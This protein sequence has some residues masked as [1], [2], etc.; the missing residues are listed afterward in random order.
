MVDAVA[1]MPYVALQ[2]MLDAGQPKGLRNRWSG[3]FV[4]DIGPDL[5]SQMQD[6]AMR[7]PSP[8]K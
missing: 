4:Q 1:P 8:L 7:L 3:G 5:V 6:S 2:A